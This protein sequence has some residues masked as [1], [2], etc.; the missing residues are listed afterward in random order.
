MTAS[1]SSAR[2]MLLVLHAGAA[3]VLIGA[4]THHALQMQHYLRGDFRRVALEKTYAKVVSVA[5]VITFILGAMVYPSYRVQVRGLY[6]DR[7]APGWSGLFDMKEVY[8]SLTP[9]RRRGPRRPRLDAAPRRVAGPRARLRHDELARVR[10]GLV[11]RHRRPAHHLGARP[12]VKA[13]RVFAML[14]VARAVYGAV[15]LAATA[16]RWPLFWY[17]PLERRWAFEATPRTSRWAGSAPPRWPSSPPRSAPP[18]VA[19][20]RARPLFQGDRA[21]RGHPRHR[22]RRRD[23]PPRR[24]RLLR[25]DAHAP[26]AAPAAH[27]RE[28][29]PP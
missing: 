17:Y 4:A 29:A 24:L 19:R 6:L 18:R 16:G 14:L 9:H 8:A 23:D 28:Q 25:L 11:R 21:P 10:G 5:Y 26:D 7:Y 13:A 12:R 20:E 1:F 15:Y 3:I 2:A 22:P 27:P